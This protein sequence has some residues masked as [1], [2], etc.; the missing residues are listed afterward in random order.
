MASDDNCSLCGLPRSLS[1]KLVWTTDGGLYFQTRRSDRLIFLEEEDISTILDEGIKIHGHKI[2]DTLREC[3]RVFT[4]G[5]INSQLTGLRRFLLRHWPLAKRVVVSSFKDAAFFGCGNI[6]ITGLKP[7]KHLEVKVRHPYHPHLIAGDIWGFWEGLYGV[8]ALLSINAS[9]EQE[10][11]I[12]VRTV[13]K[14][15]H[16]SSRE[17]LPRRPER[18]YSLEVCEK[19][20]LPRFPWELRWD[21]DL[22]TI[23]QI[24][25]HRHMIITSAR[26][27]RQI[28]DEIKGSSMK[29]LPMEIGVALAVKTAAEYGL[30]KGN[31]YKTAYRHFFLGLPFLGWGRPRKVTRKPFLIDAEMDGVP[32][33]QLLAWKMAGVYE[34]M[35][36]EPADIE[37]LQTG[38]MGWQYLIG[39][40]LD[41]TFLE[42]ERMVP[43]PGQPSYPR[44]IFPF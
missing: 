15:R 17:N 26:G 43:E 30:L 11:E 18:D 8:E 22:G 31:N 36:H 21:A 12:T 44:P 27:W 28:I 23:Y 24:G 2:L 29:E 19:C 39:P 13:Q 35:E 1:R 16:K 37:Q 33:P 25:T 42:I 9:T 41:G 32:F 34:A 7:R 6:T 4:R 3:R 14:N 20:H 38:D 40:R 5:E 10:W